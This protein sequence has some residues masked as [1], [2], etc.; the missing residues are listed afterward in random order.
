MRTT[1]DDNEDAAEEVRLLAESLKARK[2]KE[3]KT[4]IDTLRERL[5][6][7]RFLQLLSRVQ[8]QD[9][10]WTRLLMTVLESLD[11]KRLQKPDLVS[12]LQELVSAAAKVGSVFAVS[13]TR[14]T[15]AH[16]VKLVDPAATEPLKGKS[17][18]Q[19]WRILATLCAQ[20]AYFAMMGREEAQA[21]AERIS[22]LCWSAL[23]A[24][25]DEGGGGG[26]GGGGGAVGAAAATAVATTHTA[27]AGELLAS[28]VE[29]FPFALPPPTLRALLERFVAYL[30]REDSRGLEQRDLLPQ[31]WGC[32]NTLL[33]R[34]GAD[35]LG[36][37]W[38]VVVSHP[39]L[40]A[41]LTRRLAS[42]ERPALV[43]QLVQFARTALRLAVLA[44]RPP[45]QQL[46]EAV[47]A[48]VRREVHGGGGSLLRPLEAD[49]AALLRGQHPAETHAPLCFLELAAD[50]LLLEAGGRFGFGGG[51]SGSDG[52]GDGDG[53]GERAE[54]AAKRQRAAPA[55]EW[56]EGVSSGM[57]DL[58]TLCGV[59]G[60]VSG[61]VSG[62][63][64]GGRGSG[65]VDGGGMSTGRHCRRLLLLCV[66]LGRAPPLPPAA[67]GAAVR[68]LLPLAES[69]GEDE[70]VC[71]MPPR[72]C[73]Q[74]PTRDPLIQQNSP[75]DT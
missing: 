66:A 14:E 12:G 40:L 51:G 45:P 67:A 72:R 52:D 37:V 13:K 61:G 46:C 70:Q 15:M 21:L 63:V 35:A 49:Y 55:A 10:G 28:L 73:A 4:A 36:M 32:V 75:V 24:D 62:G 50:M 65:A 23:G 26:G 20:P 59:G 3:F 22:R 58:L 39:P 11:A 19:C 71:P 60:G 56:A 48:L 42:T 29:H 7:T 30:A 6:T 47:G 8:P 9:K 34:Q 74:I 1:N 38:R 16:L 5:G 69:A 27:K 25:D 68:A 53:G 43:E 44:R 18:E 41:W 2:E 33:R 57:C 54:P 31:L 17:A 64:N